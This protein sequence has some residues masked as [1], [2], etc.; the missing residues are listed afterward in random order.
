MRVIGYDLKREKRRRA[1]LGLA[2]IILLLG[3]GCTPQAGYMRKWQP[4][5]HISNRWAGG[6][7]RADRLSEDEAGVFKELGTPDIIRLYRR[8][9]TRERV[10]TWIYEASNQVI[11][12]V[13]G[14]RVDYVEVDANTLPL[15]RAEQQTLKQKAI[16]GGVVAGA[17]GAL[18]AG[19]ILFGEDIGLRN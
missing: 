7:I 6:T 5:E 10:Y 15:S 12:F 4:A 2:I 11:W 1:A 14:Q 16:A 8:V 19:F 3:S 9:P 13:D 18:A 17:V